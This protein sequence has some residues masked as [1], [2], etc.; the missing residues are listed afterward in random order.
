MEESFIIINGDKREFLKECT[1][2]ELLFE[3]GL[4][5][6]PVVVELNHEALI[7]QQFDLKVIT[8]GSTLEIVSIVAGG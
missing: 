4:S 7:P 5:D 8:K 6:K 2:K 3:L 1:V